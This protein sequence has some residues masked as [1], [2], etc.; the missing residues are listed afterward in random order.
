VLGQKQKGTLP[1]LREGGQ[2]VKLFL[3]I[4]L[5]FSISA[6]VSETDFYRLRADV[7]DLRR[8]SSLTKTELDSLR[9]KTAGAA[10][11]DTLSAVRE[12]QSETASRIRDLSSG[13]QEIRG[14]FDENR[15]FVEKSLK[16]SAA[17]RDMLRA[18]INSLES[19]MKVLRDKMAVVESG[20]RQ[21][22]EPRSQQ[23][24]SFRPEIDEKKSEPETVAEPS[25]VKD[26]ENERVKAYDAAF[27]A[28]NDKKFKESRERFEAF[29]KTYPKNDLSDNAQFWIAETYYAEKHYE[30][31]ILSYESLMKNYP[32]SRKMSGAMLKQ[33]FAFIEIG[34]PK[35]GKII[36]NRMIEKFPDSKDAELARK[37]IADLDKK[38]SGKR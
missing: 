10:K 5:L 32:E 17:E 25:E 12:S 4:L 36:L 8:D 24:S 15:Y 1:G 3:P 33:A 29:L 19:Q 38:P 2:I 13:L 7:N 9:E 6:C 35:T 18:Q 14:R 34:D 16:D 26:A 27:S 20:L 21:R 28:F 23:E 11:E 22:E 31:A 30:D 37:K